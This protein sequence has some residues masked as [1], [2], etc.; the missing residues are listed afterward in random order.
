[1]KEPDNYNVY[2]LRLRQAMDLESKI[3]LTER[4]IHDAVREFGIN[5]LYVAF[6]GGKD[7]TVM[8]DLV[9]GLYPDVTAVFS[10]TGLEYPEIRD[11][12]KTIDNVIW[13]KPQT[14]FKEVVQAKGYP[15]I[16]KRVA[17]AVRDCQNPTEK[18]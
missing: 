9:R 5:G 13:V 6:S 11:F 18:K 7:S 14:T 4:R 3:M 17:R 16:S 15:V 10:D 12:V 1:M 2:K 8:L